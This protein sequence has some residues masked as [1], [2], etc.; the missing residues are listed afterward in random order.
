MFF[1]DMTNGSSD[2][3]AVPKR[4]FIV[5][6]YVKSK[7]GISRNDLKEALEPAYIT[8][9]IKLSTSVINAAE[10]LGLIKQEDG[11]YY[12]KA[13]D[14]KTIEDMRRY[15]NGNI[16]S[17]KDGAFYKITSEIFNMTSNELMSYKQ[18]TEMARDISSH[19]SQSITHDGLR[20]WRFWGQF[21]GFGYLSNLVFMPNAALFIEDL[22]HNN[23]FSK[24]VLYS[25]DEFLDIVSPSINIILNNSDKNLKTFNYGVTCGLSTLEATGRIKT[26]HILDHDVWNTMNIG[27]GSQR[28][29]NIEIL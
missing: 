21:L 2:T 10:E 14:L 24:G 3:A 17:I 28:I 16:N 15:I 23:E 13:P 19:S 9:D 12:Q 8:S 11:F 29:T 20:A 27:L 7:N 6:Q 22:I 26:Q 1:K 25:V 4:V 18:L 5:Y